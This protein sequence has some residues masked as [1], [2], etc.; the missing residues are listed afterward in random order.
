MAL[1]KYHQLDKSNSQNRYSRSNSK[2]DLYRNI[3]PDQTLLEVTTRIKIE[4]V[5]T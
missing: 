3:I 1:M 4:I 5:D 2:N